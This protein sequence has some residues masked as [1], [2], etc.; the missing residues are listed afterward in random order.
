MWVC[1]VVSLTHSLSADVGI[2]LSRCQALVAEQ[3]L[4][5]SEIRSAIE[6]V[7]GERMTHRMRTGFGIEPRLFRV[8]L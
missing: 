6:H 4:N 8:L 5:A 2:D 7:C 1:L 3:L